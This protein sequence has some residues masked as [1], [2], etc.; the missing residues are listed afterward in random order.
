MTRRSRD[1]DKK[2]KEFEAR[3]SRMMRNRADEFSDGVDEAAERFAGR[4]KR[5]GT[6]GAKR[7]GSEIGQVARPYAPFLMILGVV[8]SAI[9]LIIGIFVINAIA[10]ATN[11][12]FMASL[13]A[14]LNNNMA[15][16]IGAS[17]F[18]SL[19]KYLTRMSR[20]L[21]L[22]LSPVFGSAGVVF[23][24]WFILSI[25][26]LS[27]ALAANSFLS[28]VSTF[29]FA[30]VWDIFTFLLVIGYVFS[31]VRLLFIVTFGPYGW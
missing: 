6:H 3:F 19:G 10:M 9:F 21:S 13:A 30:S 31:A 12:A 11:S 28:S 15:L 8:L 26:N 2:Q 23:A 17:M 27:S 14:F 1:A 5:W 24:L 16:M 25:L 4:V 7:F 22:A 18:F 29:F 20:L